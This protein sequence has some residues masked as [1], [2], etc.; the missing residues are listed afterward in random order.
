MTF[1]LYK[2]GN[3]DDFEKFKSGIYH[4]IVEWLQEKKVLPKNWEDF[5]EKHMDNLMVLF[6]DY[7]SPKGV[8]ER[9][10][11]PVEDEP[12]T[13]GIL[14]DRDK[15]GEMFY[16][17]TEVTNVWSNISAELENLMKNITDETLKEKLKPFDD[18]VSEQL[19]YWLDY[20]EN[21]RQLGK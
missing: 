21:R 19:S 17:K 12:H 11:K 16:C 14:I 4:K 9:I 3:E 6:S 8:S 1:W 13:I 5:N 18:K 10:I 2:N 7:D 20:F 15:F